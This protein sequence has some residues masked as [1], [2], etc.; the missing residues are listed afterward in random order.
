M[1]LTAHTLAEFVD[2]QL[3]MRNSLGRQLRGEIASIALENEQR[4][5]RIVFIRFSWLAEKGVDDVWVR[6]KPP[7]LF[8][9]CLDDY[10]IESWGSDRIVLVSNDKTP[11]RIGLFTQLYPS[12]L[13]PARV[14]GLLG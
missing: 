4:A 9:I 11:K 10:M 12:K 6:I 5:N 13:P 14:R 3:A 2:G 1:T 8:A 7:T